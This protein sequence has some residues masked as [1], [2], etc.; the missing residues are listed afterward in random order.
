MS[1]PRELELDIE[2]AELRITEY[3]VRID[4]DDLDE[5]LRE[6]TGEI[7]TRAD[8]KLQITENTVESNC[9]KNTFQEA[10]SDE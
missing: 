3:C 7:R 8:I 1:E 5:I 9:N 2:N 6:L 4:G 10:D